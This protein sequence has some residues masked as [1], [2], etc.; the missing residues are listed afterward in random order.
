MGKK[1][2]MGLSGEITR[3]PGDGLIH[4]YSPR[5]RHLLGLD[6]APA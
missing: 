5:A 4:M 3:R 2:A 6:P 1:C